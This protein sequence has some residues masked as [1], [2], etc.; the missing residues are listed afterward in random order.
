MFQKLRNWLANKIRGEIDIA[1]LT[2]TP[3]GMEVQQ[4]LANAIL[5][6][7][8]KE[9]KAERRWRLIRRTGFAIIFLGGFFFYLLVYASA[10]GFR[11]NFL[12]D[13]GIDPQIGVVRISGTIGAGGRGASADEI[14][15]AIRKALEAKRTKVVVLQIDSPGGAPVAAERIAR[16]L[17]ALREEHE[18][19]IYAVI[20]NVGTSAAY[21]VALETDRIYAGQYSLVGSI[22]AVLSAWDVH[23]LMERLEIEHR[24]FTSGE[25]KQMLNP[26]AAPSASG[27]AKAQAL[28]D[29]VGGF[30]AQD[31]AQARAGRLNALI[32]YATGEVWSGQRALEIGLIDEIGSLETIQGQTGISKMKRYR[33]VEQRTLLGAFN[34]FGF[35]IGQGLMSPFSESIMS[36]R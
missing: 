1:E 6:D 5:G 29:E 17:R 10:A 8:L 12:P 27:D 18:K 4:A 36:L 32:N 34:D 30:F 25:L 3:T 15:A 13:W 19:P 23:R 14:I 7:I 35:H 16:A 2:H 26:F 21:M 20:D 28:V 24:A 31:V 11:I 9:R 33:T 22:G